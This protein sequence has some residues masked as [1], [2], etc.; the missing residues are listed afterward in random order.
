[1]DL[2]F[3]RALTTFS[4]EYQSSPDPT[5]CLTAL[6][7]GD[8]AFLVGVKT[9]W[10]NFLIG[11]AFDSNLPLKSNDIPDQLSASRLYYRAAMLGGP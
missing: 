3:R 2:D 7:A 5:V 10:D 11:L 8:M 9:K 6:Y 1:M 4:K